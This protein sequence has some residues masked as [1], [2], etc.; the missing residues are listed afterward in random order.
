MPLPR[1]TKPQTP[2]SVS[3]DI[4]IE[5]NRR[6]AQLA[7]APQEAARMIAAGGIGE[8]RIAEYKARNAG[9]TELAAIYRTAIDNAERIK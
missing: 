8:V 1:T 4:V 2:E 9:D 6:A 5:A 3:A 7:R